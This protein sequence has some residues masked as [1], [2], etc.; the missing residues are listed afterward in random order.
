VQAR[1]A[2]EPP[3][4]P[5]RD[6]RPAL[7]LLRLAHEQ[8]RSTLDERAAKA[9]LAAAGLAV[10]RERLAT[11]PGRSRRRQPVPSPP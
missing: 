5:A 6:L 11:S 8:G 7:D 1:P 4:R 2:P 3:S 10:T 9:V